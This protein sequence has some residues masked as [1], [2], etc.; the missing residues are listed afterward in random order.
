MADPVQSGAH[1]APHLVQLGAIV[2]PH[3][4]RG[5]VKVKSFTEPPARLFEYGP[6]MDGQGAARFTLKRLGGGD[7]ARG[8]F[9]AALAGVD[10]RNQAEGLRGQGLYVPR[11]RLPATASDEYY[12]ADLIG[13]AVE[14]A[15]GVALGQIRAVVNF[16]AG[17]ILEILTPRG[18]EYLPFTD[19]AVPTVDL[20]AGRVIAD[21]AFLL[22][23]TGGPDDASA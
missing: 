1:G 17:D 4:V 9:I 13:L 7:A 16:G 19:A 11:A 21:P 2:A 23:R 12:H 22:G 18:V 3:G 5:A 6:L 10:D 15:A 8:L 20:A 14:D